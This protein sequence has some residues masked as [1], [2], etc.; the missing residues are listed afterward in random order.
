MLLDMLLLPDAPATHGTNAQKMTDGAM[1][2]VE[3]LFKK[4]KR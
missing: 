1:G 3:G 4:L 2:L